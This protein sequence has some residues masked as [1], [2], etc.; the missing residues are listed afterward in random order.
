MLRGGYGIFWLPNSLLSTSTSQRSAPWSAT[1]TF[2]GSLDGGITPF[3][4]LDNPFPNGI[5]APPGSSGGLNSLIGQAQQVYERSTHPGYMQN[6]NFDIQQ[7]LW[8]D[9]VAD[10]AYAGS[11]GTGLPVNVELNQLPD[12]YLA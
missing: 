2:V 8:H 3:G 10:V 5:Q 9:I 12:Q 4:S 6:W 11:K 1:T 7:N